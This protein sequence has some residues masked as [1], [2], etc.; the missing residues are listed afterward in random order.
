MGAAKLCT[1]TPDDQPA[2]FGDMFARK[3]THASLFTLQLSIFNDDKLPSL[4]PSAAPC[5]KVLDQQLPIRF[6]EEPP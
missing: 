5:P 3:E 1:L 6:P 4:S 2:F